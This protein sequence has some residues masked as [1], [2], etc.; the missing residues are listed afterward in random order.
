[1]NVGHTT[2][3]R[4]CEVHRHRHA[5]LLRHIPN[6]VRFQNSTGGGQVRMNLAHGALRTQHLERLFQIDI[7]SGK[8]GRGAFVRDL[9]QQIRVGPRNYVLHPR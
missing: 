4:S 9:L 1:M 6:L 5:K 8:N 3:G 7:L 2:H